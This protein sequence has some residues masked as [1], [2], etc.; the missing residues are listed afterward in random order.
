MET[1]KLASAYSRTISGKSNA[2]VA[3]PEE[4]NVCEFS[5]PLCNNI[6]KVRNYYV[7]RPYNFMM[8]LDQWSSITNKI[9]LL[10]AIRFGMEWDTNNFP[11]GY[12]SDPAFHTQMYIKFH[13]Y[14]MKNVMREA[15]KIVAEF[16]KAVFKARFLMTFTIDEVKDIPHLKTHDQLQSALMKAKNLQNQIDKINVIDATRDMFLIQNNR[17][18]ITINRN[19][20]I[21]V[22]KQDFNPHMIQILKSQ[23]IYLGDPDNVL[24]K[25]IHNTP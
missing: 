4:K 23:G 25:K 13:K 15:P 12:L 1:T 9:E 14:L 16:Q 19:M 20:F 8:N 11:E 18:P 5:E 2:W 6:I 10:T 3:F 24:Y 22:F 7:T 21:D 17:G